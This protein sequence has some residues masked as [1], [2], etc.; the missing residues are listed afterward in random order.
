MRNTRRREYD[1]SSSDSDNPSKR[2]PFP[3]MPNFDISGKL[4]NINLLDMVD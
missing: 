1:D 3:K 2:K 4:G